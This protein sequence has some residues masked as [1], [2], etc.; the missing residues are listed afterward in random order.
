MLQDAFPDLNSFGGVLLIG[1]TITLTAS[2]FALVICQ[3]CGQQ[4]R[5][6]QT[7]KR[8]STLILPEVVT[9]MHQTRVKLT[10]RWGTETSIVHKQGR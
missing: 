7:G 10:D 1:G 9:P 3:L 5:Q 8:K 4:R 6:R 2:C